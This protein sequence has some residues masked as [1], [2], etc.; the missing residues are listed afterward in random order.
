ME[1][2][3]DGYFISNDEVNKGK[4]I[5]SYIGIGTIAWKVMRFIIASPV[6]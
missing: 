1:K 3:V 5:L 2:R 4:K 6:R